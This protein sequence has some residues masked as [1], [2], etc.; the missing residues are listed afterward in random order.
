M[1]RALNESESNFENL[2]LWPFEHRPLTGWGG[3]SSS[4]DGDW[5]EVFI[6]SR[7]IVR[8]VI[9]QQCDDGRVLSFNLTAMSDDV[10]HIFHFVS[11]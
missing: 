1:H 9:I 6:G 4:Y 10:S 11:A 3:R 2:R 5:V 8:D 7:A